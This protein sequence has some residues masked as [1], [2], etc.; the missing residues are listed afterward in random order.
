MGHALLLARCLKDMGHFV[1]LDMSNWA[2][3]MKRLTK[4]ILD[5]EKSQ[6]KEEDGV[7]TF[8]TADCL[9]FMNDWKKKTYDKL[10]FELGESSDNY[11]PNGI[12]FAASAS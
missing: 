7:N 6:L 4:V 9:K 10:V 8:S 2:T 12:M 11:F 5:T 3:T 1:E